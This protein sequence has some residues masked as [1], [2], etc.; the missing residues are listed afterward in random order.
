MTN[1]L[2]QDRQIKPVVNT[3]LDISTRCA[4]TVPTSLGFRLEYSTNLSPVHPEEDGIVIRVTPRLD[5]LR[6]P[7]NT[8]R[9]AVNE[10]HAVDDSKTLSTGQPQHRDYYFSQTPQLQSTIQNFLSDLGISEI[11]DGEA[12]AQTCHALITTTLTFIKSADK[13]NIGSKCSELQQRFTQQRATQQRF[14]QQNTNQLT[15]QISALITSLDH[16]A[17]QRGLIFEHQ[18]ESARTSLI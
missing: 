18:L 16:L 13:P 14:S 3:T 2:E 15:M 12:A 8:G 9:T 17:Q 1:G 6:H 4:N 10:L 5:N 11:P 7:V